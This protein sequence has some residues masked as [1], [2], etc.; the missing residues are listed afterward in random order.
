MV[1]LNHVVQ[2]LV[3]SQLGG[4]EQS[5]FLLQFSK[6]WRISLMLVGINHP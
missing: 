1:L 2:V 3:L 5:L 6:G 4:L